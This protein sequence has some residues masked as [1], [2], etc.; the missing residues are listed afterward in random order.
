[1]TQRQVKDEAL[2]KFK[3][4][5]DVVL[6]KY[7][8]KINSIY[9]TGSALTDDFNSKTSDVNSIFVLKEMDLNFLESFAPLGKKFGKKQVASPL[10]MT[11][12]YIMNS[13]DVFPIEFLTIKSL[14]FGLNSI[15]PILSMP[16]I[17]C[18][19]LISSS[20]DICFSHCLSLSSACE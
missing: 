3:P 14:N 18:M 12:E 9:I 7:K 10:I 19:K 5:L 16:P 11:S 13:L 6:N 20:G 8:D 2:S 17:L 4:F 1:M 15:F